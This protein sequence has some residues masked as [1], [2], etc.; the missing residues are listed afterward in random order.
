MNVPVEFSANTAIKGKLTTDHSQSSYSQPVLI[1][2][3]IAYGPGNLIPA[4]VVGLRPR[5][6]VDDD[7]FP[8]YRPFIS[9]YAP[10]AEVKAAWNASVSAARDR[11][12]FGDY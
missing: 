5:V 8:F 6:C 12:V 9:G 7:S 4:E 1:V 2:A 11:E 10:D 3:G